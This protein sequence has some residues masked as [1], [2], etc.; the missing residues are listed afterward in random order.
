MAM[1]E[2]VLNAWLKNPGERVAAGEAI[3]EIE[4][5]KSALD[6]ESP[7]DGVLG[8]HLVSA[9]ASVPVGHV[10]VRVLEPGEIEP[11]DGDGPHAPAET[12]AD[13]AG[14]PVAPVAAGAAGAA[15]AAAD[16]RDETVRAGP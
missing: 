14:A 16:A 10:I 1:T 13:A 4:T 12:A 5:D 15:V 8:R 2:A 11:R 7:G 9:G 3:A 6:V